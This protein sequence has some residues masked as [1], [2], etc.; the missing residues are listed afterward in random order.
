MYFMQTRTAIIAL[1]K[2]FSFLLLASLSVLYLGN[3]IAVF[4]CN[5]KL[6]LG[7]ILTEFFDEYL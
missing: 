5:Y 6:G 4:S 2:N 7:Q 3:D 1:T